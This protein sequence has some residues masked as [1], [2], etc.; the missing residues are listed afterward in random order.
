M[1]P[2]ILQALQMTEIKTEN[3]NQ[4]IGKILKAKRL[5]SAISVEDS[6]AYL[7]VKKND[8][9]AIESDDFEKLSAHIYALGFVRSYAKFLK[10]E[11]QIEEKVKNLLVK[12]NVE[13][14]EHLLVNIGEDK[15][16]SPNRD[17]LFNALLVSILLFLVL[18][19]IYNFVETDNN[20]ISSEILIRELENSNPHE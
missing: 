8:I 2:K 1:Q 20:L 5:E 4:S 9:E 16:F 11:T 18:L 10:V 14:K 13:N 7:K 17:L 19:S 3:N 12:S 15:K 6:C